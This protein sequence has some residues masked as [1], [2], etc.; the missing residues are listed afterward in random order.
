MAVLLCGWGW[1]EGKLQDNLALRLGEGRMLVRSA[2]KTL[3]GG[4][5]TLS[6]RLEKTNMQGSALSAWVIVCLNMPDPHIK[7]SNAK[8]EMQRIL[9]LYSF[10]NEINSIINLE[11]G[12]AR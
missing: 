2:L 7:I 4:Q 8:D 11:E 6:T 5:F 1:G 12:S 3:Y 9:R 10:L